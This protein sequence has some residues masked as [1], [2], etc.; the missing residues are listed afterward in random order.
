MTDDQRAALDALTARRRAFVLAYIGEARGNA[1]D[2]ARRA[3]YAHPDPEG[4]RLLGDARV[5]AAILAFRETVE[6]ATVATVEE[7]RTLWTAI[8]RGEVQDVTRDGEKAPAGLAARLR[9]SELLGKSQG[10][11]LDRHEVTGREGAPVG[12]PVVV[13]SYDV[14]A[15]LARGD[16]ESER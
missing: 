7:L 1:T 3:G 10:A 2:A 5:S 9:A 13:L 14:A 15:R 16:E 6:A 12:A 11:F 8:A 4:A